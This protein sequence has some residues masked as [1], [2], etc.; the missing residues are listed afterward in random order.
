MMNDLGD[1]WRLKATVFPK[2][3]VPPRTGKSR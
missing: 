3:T 2:G 1:S